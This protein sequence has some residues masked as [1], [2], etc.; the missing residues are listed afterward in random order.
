MYRLFGLAAGAAL[1]IAFIDSVVS[2]PENILDINDYYE[3][4]Q[5]PENK[6]FQIYGVLKPS[7]FY[8]NPDTN[9]YHF[10]LTNYE[11]EVDVIY[12]G[13]LPME[14]KEGE[15]LIITCYLPNKKNRSRIVAH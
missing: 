6:D 11:K 9:N 13:F 2:N 7:S 15:N 4:D 3:Y 8:L 10:T 5:L 12:K 1:T 14:L